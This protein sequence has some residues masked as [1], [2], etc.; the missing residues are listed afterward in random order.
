MAARGAERAAA[1][2]LAAAVVRRAAGRRAPAD[3]TAG[4]VS[5]ALAAANAESVVAQDA[6]VPCVEMALLHRRRRRTSAA[7]R[8]RVVRQCANC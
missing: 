5:E 3:P 8:L 6:R 4:T 1:A 7:S 2:H